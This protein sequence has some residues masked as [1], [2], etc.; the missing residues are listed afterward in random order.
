MDILNLFSWKGYFL[1]STVVGVYVYLR[2]SY[3]AI[4]VSIWFVRGTIEEYLITKT[5]KEE[6]KIKLKKQ[7]KK[8]K[9]RTQYEKIKFKIAFSVYSK[10]YIWGILL[11][12]ILVI[13]ISLAIPIY[14]TKFIEWFFFEDYSNERWIYILGNYISWFLGTVRLVMIGTIVMSFFSIIKGFIKES[15]FKD[16]I[17][18]AR[19]LILLDAIILTIFNILEV[20]IYVGWGDIQTPLY[21]YYINWLHLG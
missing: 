10:I 14:I 17:E 18:K 6:L 3:Y 12:F 7:L 20:L 11:L 2:L 19:V 16:A 9:I 1:F 4:Y 13:I 8:I 15:Y 5:Y 21:K